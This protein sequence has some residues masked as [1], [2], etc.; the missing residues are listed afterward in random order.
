[1]MAER[2]LGTDRHAGMFFVHLAAL[3]MTL[4]FLWAAGEAQGAADPAIRAPSVKTGA[5]PHPDET[6]D[7]P[8]IEIAIAA[9]NQYIWRGYEMSRNSM[10][11]QPS[12]TL[13]YKGFS[14]NLWGNLDT[15]AYNPDPG[16]D[17]GTKWNESDLTLSYSKKLGRFKV[18]GGYILYYFHGNHEGD[19]KRGENAQALYLSIAPGILL[20]PTLAVYKDIAHDREWYFL[21]ETSHIF[22]LS[23][24]LSLIFGG[25]ASYLKSTYADRD[26]FNA[27]RSYSGYPKFDGNARATTELFDNFHDGAVFASLT[28]KV[29]NRFSVMP[30]ISYIF[31]LSNDAGNE[32]KGQGLKGTANPADRRC[33]FLVGGFTAIVAF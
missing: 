2:N 6:Q 7:K 4:L 1:M 28:I 24:T 32:M 17:Y 30:N 27:G 19:K 3:F 22:E 5:T 29:T 11:V 33:S 18:E 21:L 10:V 15:K 13:D 23:K 31:P 14:L 20:S 12:L 8:R 25:Y 16:T 9:L 26:L